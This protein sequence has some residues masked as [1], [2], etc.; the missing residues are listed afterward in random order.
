MTA[1]FG[2]SKTE[3]TT[4]VMQAERPF[5]LQY[6]GREMLSLFKTEFAYL[7]GWPYFS[8]IRS[9]LG[10]GAFSWAPQKISS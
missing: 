5:L 6:I 1:L 7:S 9:F 10:G 4:H 2:A 3:D 8:S